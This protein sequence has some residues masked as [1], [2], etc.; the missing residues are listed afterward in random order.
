M[1]GEEYSASVKVVR[2]LASA[3]AVLLAAC[4]GGGGAESHPS[5]SPQPASAPL[6]M[7]GGCGATT[8]LKGGIPDWLDVAGGHNNPASIPYALATPPRSAAG[9]I[10]GYPLLAEHP[11]NRNNKILWVVGSPRQGSP[12]VI[13]AHPAGA[14]APIVSQSVPAD[15]APGEIYPS[16]DDVPKPGCWH[17]DLA[18]AGHRAALDLLYS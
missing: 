3:V 13:T 1:R 14:T 5:P 10:F 18:W 15:S 17:F 11:P 6:V 16:L 12:L 7:V 4:S 9:F 8:V 2:P